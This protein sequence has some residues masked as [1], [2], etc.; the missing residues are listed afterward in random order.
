MGLWRLNR[1]L[2]VQGMG[3]VGDRC[4]EFPLEKE[5]WVC[6]WFGHMLC[7]LLRSFTHCLCLRPDLQGSEI[8]LCVCVRVCVCVCWCGES[9]QP[10][11]HRGD[12]VAVGSRLPEK[13]HSSFL[14]SCS[15]GFSWVLRMANFCW[16][17]ILQ[18]KPVARKAWCESDREEGRE[19]RLARARREKLVAMKQR[20]LHLSGETH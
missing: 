12:P 10:A 13:M 15:P 6:V 3:M 18:A 7:G 16:G 17:P 8:F 11:S 1:G 4:P 5:G 9:S 2:L 14:A 20:L 19:S